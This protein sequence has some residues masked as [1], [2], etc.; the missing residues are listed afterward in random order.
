MDTWQVL[1]LFVSLRH[2]GT[3]FHLDLGDLATW[4]LVLV[5]VGA[6]IAAGLAYRKQSSS[7]DHLA[8][9]VKTQ[10]D[11]LAEQRKATKA[12]ADQAKAQRLAL[13]DQQ[14]VNTLQVRL[15][16]RNLTALAR[17][18][19]DQV[20]FELGVSYELMP[21]KK[22]EPGET[23]H[24]VKVTNGSAR[25]IR[26]VAARIFAPLDEVNHPAAVVAMEKEFTATM[27]V[28]AGG[29]GVLHV[30]DDHL[31]EDRI[32]V[33]RAEQ[34]GVLIFPLDASQEAVATVRFTDDAGLHWEV[35]DDLH[36]EQ[37]DSRDW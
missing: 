29:T 14:R 17:Q 35:E 16:E 24:Q 7:D 21:G 9:Q 33:L 25:P 23:F 11:A 4:A 3:A 31:E 36:L 12:L 30:L 32:Y 18:Q 34:V 19:A 28:M 8:E 22:R 15:L 27:S 37:L 26:Q 6:L 1:A 20:S 10:G 2:P 13:E 5:T